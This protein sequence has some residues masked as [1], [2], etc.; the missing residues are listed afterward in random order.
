MNR[1]RA[2]KPIPVVKAKASKKVAPIKAKP[3]KKSAIKKPTSKAV[4]KKNPI[5]T[6][7]GRLIFPK[8]APAKRPAAKKIALDKK[9]PAR[10][11]A[12]SAKAKTPIRKKPT[13]APK[14]KVA[15]KK[16]TRTAKVPIKQPAAKRPAKA[17]INPWK[18]SSPAK[19]VK[20][21]KTAPNVKNKAKQKQRP[22]PKVKDA[23]KQAPIKR[24]QAV[25]SKAIKKPAKQAP[26]KRKQ[27]V[28]ST[29]IK[30]PAKQAPK[31]K[32]QPA[33]QPKGK[34]IK[35]L[36]TKGTL[37]AKAQTGKSATKKKAPA[38]GKKPVK[39][40]IGNQPAK[41]KSARKPSKNLGNYNK[42]SSIVSSFINEKKIN[43]AEGGITFHE[44]V[45]NI[46][47]YQKSQKVTLKDLSN[48]IDI[49]FYQHA[50]FKSEIK[51]PDN[52]PF[53]NGDSLL[54]PQ[55]LDSNFEIAV[56]ANLP[57]EAGDK[58]DWFYRGTIETMLEEFAGEPKQFCRK[59]YNDSPVAYFKFM[60]SDRGEGV[61]FYELQADA[62]PSSAAPEGKF[63]P[64]PS[65]EF[66]LDQPGTD[67][68]TGG[69]TPP[70]KPTPVA[71]PKPPTV[72]ETAKQIELSKQKESELNA[73][74]SA[75]KVE[76]EKMQ[77]RIELINTYKALYDSQVISLEEFK[78]YIA[79]I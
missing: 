11:K 54:K 26:T 28:V 67:Q 73:K 42:V 45:Q 31:A 62:E 75:D 36:P 66:G 15:A 1:K 7:M 47:F 27:A 22:L 14:K 65:D 35:R 46:Y 56:S 63:G 69:A 68:P 79:G 8:K 44:A 78:K 21:A 24:K 58:L 23:T 16:I 72:E 30:K 40:D 61:V 74:A 49:I 18:I 76:I 3:I 52:I 77:K 41:K 64:P 4:V 55:Y 33:L 70:K 25:V 17:P 12:I 34:V 57:G 20:P 50:G 19:P 43:L 2:K 71:Q 10:S 53:Y 39:A 38:K 51:W 29:A 32:E 13:P 9:L 60:S 59:Y 5:K 37:P 6:T 48:N